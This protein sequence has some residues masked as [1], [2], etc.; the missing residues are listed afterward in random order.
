L[1]NGVGASGGGGSATLVPRAQE[2]QN[3]WLNDIIQG[4]SKSSGKK[5]K[6]N[7]ELAS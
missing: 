6:F 5:G 2:D 1:P 4:E 7:L 3:T